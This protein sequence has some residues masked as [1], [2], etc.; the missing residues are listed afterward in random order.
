MSTLRLL[1]LLRRP[2]RPFGSLR[3]SVL[4][5][6]RGIADAPALSPAHERI[7]SG[8]AKMTRRGARWWRWWPPAKRPA[9]L[10]L[11][12]K[13]PLAEVQGRGRGAVRGGRE[14]Y[15]GRVSFIH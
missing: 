9:L 4:Q 11:T 10:S 8:E 5:A 2:A 7:V 6:A 1:P 3:V 13:G 12:L 15:W 14:M